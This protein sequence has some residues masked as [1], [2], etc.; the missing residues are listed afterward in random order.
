MKRFLLLLSILLLFPLITFAQNSSLLKDAQD[1][2]TAGD[3]YAALTKYQEAVK[4]LSGRDRNIAQIQLGMAKT[5]VEALSKAKTAESTKNYDAA[6]AEY[7]KV[8]DANPND[9]RVKGL[10]EAVRKSRRDA[11]PTLSVS[12]NSLSFSS[13]G[14]TQSITVNCSMNWTLVDQTSSI[15]SVS[16]SGEIINVTCSSNYGTGTRNTSF[17]VKTV[18]GAKEQRISIS[19]TGRASTSSSSYSRYTTASRLEVRPASISL[20]NLGGTAIINVSTDANDYSIS[21]LP[22]WAKVKSKYGTWFSLAYTEN[23]GYYPRSDW[24]NVTAGSKTVKVT[25]TQSGNSLGRTTS[26][27]SSRSSRT[28]NPSHSLSNDHYEKYSNKQWGV[29]TFVDVGLSDNDN[30]LYVL[31]YGAGAE[32]RLKE[33]NSRSNF[34]VGADIMRT[35]YHYYDYGSVFVTHLI[36]PAYF[37]FSIGDDSS[38]NVYLSAG[39]QIGIGLEGKS[40]STPFALVGRWGV[41]F[42]HFDMNM[43]LLGY[44]SPLVSNMAGSP[45]VGFRMTYYF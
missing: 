13:S 1:L 25:I 33:F 15:C 19:Q 11:N 20:S 34:V 30:L 41:C 21:L 45:S 38:G 7:Q 22:S 16:R 39:A 42:H 12:K 17:L 36:A 3:Y 8:L 18:N 23:T 31:S 5:C 27:S 26:S 28:Y 32:Y 10:Q 29:S 44:V 35:A 37:N 4:K 2:F 14:G 6:I 24:F 40:V 43:Y 9:T